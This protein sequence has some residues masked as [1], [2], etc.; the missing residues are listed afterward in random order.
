MK[1]DSP[2]PRYGILC[3]DSH[4]KKFLLR[5]RGFEAN[6]VHAFGRNN[7]FIFYFR[8]EAEQS[9]KEQESW[10]RKAFKM[11]VVKLI[12]TYT[13][14]DSNCREIFDEK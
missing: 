11:K 8:A 5:G 4:G 3:E 12:E 2:I 1:I 14:V 7:Y 13:T 10:A 6:K 9:L